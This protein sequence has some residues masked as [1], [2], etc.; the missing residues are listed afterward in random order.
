[1][2]NENPLSADITLSNGT[3]LTMTRQEIEGQEVKWVS[4]PSWAAKLTTKQILEAYS[5]AD[6]KVL[7]GS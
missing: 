3:E 1:M 5:L 2:A 7:S 6:K 4:A